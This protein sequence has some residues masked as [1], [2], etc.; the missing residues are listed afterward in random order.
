MS[1]QSA[2]SNITAAAS[3]QPAQKQQNLDSTS[4]NTSK[5]GSSTNSSSDISRNASNSSM[6]VNGTTSSGKDP[7]ELAQQINS[8]IQELESTSVEEEEHE[9]TLG[10]LK[11]K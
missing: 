6:S 9:R 3:Q 8:K 11:R 4:T 2:K 5:T 7:M 10:D 1:D